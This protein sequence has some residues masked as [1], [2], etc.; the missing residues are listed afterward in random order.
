[1]AKYS[2][3]AFRED[4]VA[5]LQRSEKSIAQGALTNSKRPECFVKGVYP[6]HVD[7]GYGSTLYF[8]DKCW[9]DFICALGTNLFGYGNHYITN[10]VAHVITTGAN[11]SLSTD[12]E[13]MAAEKAQSLWSECERVKFFKNGSDACSAAIRI[14]RTYTG[15]D[16]VLSLGYHGS[17]DDFT[18][19]TEPALGVPKRGWIGSYKDYSGKDADNIAAIIIE[20]VELDLSDKR[21]EEIQ[22]L[23]D[24]CTSK[25]IVL[26]FDEIITG[27]R[28]PKLSVSNY[29]GIKPDIACFGKAIGGGHSISL[30]GGRIDI[31]NCGDY[32]LSNTFNGERTGLAAFLASAALLGK[33][34]LNGNKTIDDLWLEAQTFWSSLNEICDG[35][36][37]FEGYPTRGRLVGSDI[38]KAMF[39]QEC[40]KAGVLFGPSYFYNFTHSAHRDQVKSTVCGVIKSLKMGLVKLEGEMPKAPMADKLR[41]G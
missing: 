15:K 34:A 2:Y 38:S 20:P 14:A 28:F 24:F 37:Q 39:M 12:L 21:R 1:M 30:V 29:W 26:I 16:L 22:N 41:K 36:V 17:D 19:L 32:F 10:A 18:S 23:R 13:I 9:V 4:Q 25:G 5:L 40:C 7:R 27:F 6:N 3:T 8:K 35:Y 33:P 11:L 31:M